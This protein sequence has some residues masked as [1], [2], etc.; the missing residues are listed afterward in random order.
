MNGEKATA[1]PRAADT[2]VTSNVSE[3]QALGPRIIEAVLLALGHGTHT[4]NHSVLLIDATNSPAVEGAGYY[5]SR[6]QLRALTAHGKVTIEHEDRT[7][8]P[9]LCAGGAYESGL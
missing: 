8:A 1:A 6:Y 7:G 5:K 9:L 3:L 4:S 2:D